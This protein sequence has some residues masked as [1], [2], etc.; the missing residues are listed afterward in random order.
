MADRW[1]FELYE[2]IWKDPK[3]PVYRIKKAGSDEEKMLHRNLI[4]PANFL[5][6]EVDQENVEDVMS[7]GGSSYGQVPS[8]NIL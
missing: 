4:M 6:L 1:K 8:N 2:V 7:F 3:L 5:P